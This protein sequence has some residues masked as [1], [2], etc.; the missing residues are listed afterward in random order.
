MDKRWK[1]VNKSNTVYIY[2]TIQHTLMSLCGL[3]NNSALKIILKI[4]LLLELQQLIHFMSIFLKKK[5]TNKKT[6]QKTN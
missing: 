1:Q 4:I 6:K 5:Q 2:Y 3:F